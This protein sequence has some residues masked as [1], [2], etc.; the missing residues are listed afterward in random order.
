MFFN[1][2]KFFVAN[3]TNGINSFAAY[4]GNGSLIDEYTTESPVR[5]IYSINNV[6]LAGTENGCYITLLDDNSISDIGESKLI[7]AE[8]LTIYDIF[9]DGSRLILS[10]GSEG[11]LVYDWD[12]IDT[13]PS[14]NLRIFPINSDYSTTGRFYNGMY[15]IGTEQ[16]LQI[17]NI[18]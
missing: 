5:S 17:Y 14:E 15:F 6:I 16:G 11:I 4:E 1:N 12:G 7:I 3:P 9:Y 2:D 8:D 13:N 10:S 18:Q